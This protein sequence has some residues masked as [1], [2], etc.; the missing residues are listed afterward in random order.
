V[1]YADWFRGYG[2][3]LIIHHGDQD[4]T[5]I[6]HLSE[7]TKRKGE[8]VE[9]GE[10]I[11]HAGATGSVDGCLVHFEIWHGGRPEDP[12]KWLYASSGRR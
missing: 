6:A 11:G 12:L 10:I 7:L 8:R 9:A 4:Y 5:I 1:A 3:L 2:K